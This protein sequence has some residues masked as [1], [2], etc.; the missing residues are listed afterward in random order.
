MIFLTLFFKDFFRYSH[1]HFQQR[2]YLFQLS[3]Y[4]WLTLAQATEANLLFL[5]VLFQLGDSNPWVPHAHF[6]GS[7]R[8]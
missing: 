6:R 3:S 8:V 4:T 5:A 1:Y 7:D 2:P